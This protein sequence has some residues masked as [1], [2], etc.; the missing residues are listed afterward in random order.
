[1]SKLKSPIIKFRMEMILMNAPNIWGQGQLFTAS[2]IDEVTDF[3]CGLCGYL[4]GDKIGIIFKI[5]FEFELYFSD[6]SFKNI[7]YK[8]VTSDYIEALT[9]NEVISF[10]MLNAYTVIGKY[11]S[12]CQINYSYTNTKSNDYC[13][14]LIAK[15]GF[16]S[17]GIGNTEEEAATR[18]E[19][20]I[21]SNYEHEKSKKLAYYEKFH[22]S[23][24]HKSLYSKCLSVMKSQINTPE[25]NYKHI[26]STPERY[27]HRYLWLWDSCF[28]A[29]GFRHI[30]AKIAQDL[31]LS[32]FECQ[33]E[34]GFIPHVTTIDWASDITQPPVIA[35]AALKVFEKTGNEEFLKYIFNKNKSFLNWCE[36]NRRKSDLQLYTWHRSNDA[37]CRC[38]ESGMDNSTRFD[39]KSELFAIDFSCFMANEMRCMAQIADILNY[40]IEANEY[41]LK[42]NAIKND[43]NSKLWSEK[44]G[45]YYD[46]DIDNH[47]FHNISSVASFLPLFS[48]VC[49]SRQ[50]E[51][52]I[53][54]LSDKS[55]YNSAFPIPSLTKKSSYFGDDMWRGPVWIN[56]NYMIAEGL[57]SFGYNAISDDIIAKTVGYVEKYYLQ[58]GTLYEFYDSEDERPPYLLNRK[59]AVLLPYNPSIKMQSIREYGW[60]TT[61]TFD[62]LN[63][64]DL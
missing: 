30:D 3:N 10:I 25:G 64:T 53:A 63:S 24:K 14:K 8:A 36:E 13:V 33:S 47:C 37:N 45:F 28:H 50:A 39:T 57:K 62:L 11:S 9:D 19:H 59:G 26:W 29:I 43:I 61:L 48:G 15:N 31:I 41:N 23:G 55:E 6:I 34:D 35:Y 2:G 46:Y 40:N 22:Y 1:M 12:K 7:E 44:D 49:E 18:A 17:F 38:D 58:T 52:L 56:Y 4:S 21:L 60:T 32:I 16:Y 5:P 51:K 42:F 27:P 54:K 20:G